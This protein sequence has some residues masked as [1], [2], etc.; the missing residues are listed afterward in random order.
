MGF[1]IEK[2]Y[3]SETKAIN[4]RGL[5]IAERSKVSTLACPRLAL[6]YDLSCF[7]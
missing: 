2:S 7:A 3:L 1:D 4:I 5:K 6:K